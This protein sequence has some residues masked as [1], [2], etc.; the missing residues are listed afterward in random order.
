[1]SGVAQR[2]R[3]RLRRPSRPLTD[4]AVVVG[5]C[6]VTTALALTPA[7]RGLGPPGTGYL[8]LTVAAAAATTGA[9]ILAEV[10][11]RIRDDLRWSWAAAAFALYGVLVLPVSVLDPGAVVPALMRVKVIAY[12]TAL[13]L[14]VVSLWAPRRGGTLL[15]WGITIAGAVLAT[16][17]LALP[18]DVVSTRAMTVMIT[19][20]VLPAWTTVAVGYV[21]EG[22]QRHGGARRRLGL[23]LAVVAG[24]QLY[25]AAT[26][27]PLSDPPFAALRL[28]GVLVVLLA[29]AQLVARSLEA[30]RSQQWAQQEE[31]AVAALHVERAQELAA[32]RDHE[33]RNG[34]AG[35]AGI[36]H[37]LSSGA[38]D[39]EQQRLKLA[40]LSELSRLH[41]ILDGGAVAPEPG[42]REAYAVE[43]VLAGL[44]TLRRSA[45]V[46]V[47]LQIDHGTAAADVPADTSDGGTADPPLRACGD[48]AVLAQVVTN[49]LANCDRHAPGAPVRVRAYRRAN[50]VVV[51]VRD[52]GPGL[53]TALGHDLLR[54]GVHDPAGGGSGLGLHISA[55]LMDRESGEL[56]L[57]TVTDP[58]GCLATVRLPAAGAPDRPGAGRSGAAPTR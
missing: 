9:A 49:L 56:D 17:S 20:V 45:G 16:A 22:Y 30:V 15:P 19:V 32:E 7:L 12:L 4:A 8:V 24:A 54:R 29:L 51:E 39:Q 38:D 21:V 28:V 58:P 2:V 25:R 35:L 47:T 37:L 52:E 46:P 33:L 10:V 53:R 13:P 57:R 31:L 3:G 27:M 44:V 55:R 1:M 36:T 48:A 40:V 50:Q 41:A 43:P 34:L 23:G 42:R 14:L 26:G 5:L 11:G 6:A 18:E